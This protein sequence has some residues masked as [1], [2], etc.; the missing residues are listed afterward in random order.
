MNSTQAFGLLL[1]SARNMKAQGLSKSKRHMMLYHILF[2]IK[3][4]PI[5]KDK[6]RAHFQSGF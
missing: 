3:T 1:R 2:T 6:N 4:Y 5:H